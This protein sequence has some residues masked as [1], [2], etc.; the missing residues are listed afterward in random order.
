M[1]DCNPGPVEPVEEP[2][3][4]PW[5][6][7]AEDDTTNIKVVPIEVT[8]DHST[9]ELEGLFFDTWAGYTEDDE[10]ETEMTIEKDKL[11]RSTRYFIGRFFYDVAARAKIVYSVYLDGRKIDD[12]GTGLPYASGTGTM[13]PTLFRWPNSAK[14]N[15]PGPHKVRVEYALITGIAESAL[16]LLDWGTLKSKKTAEF[17]V[18]LLPNKEPRD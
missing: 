14:A 6:P 2:A 5:N 10:P 1:S 8:D 3:E 17:T 9:V 11:D 12:Y 13:D 4:E 7:T 15:K 16:G 18:T